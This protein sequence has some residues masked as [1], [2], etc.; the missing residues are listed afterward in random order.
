MI[1]ANEEIANKSNK[2]PALQMIIDELDESYNYGFDSI[3]TQKT[4][5][6]FQV[7]FSEYSSFYWGCVK[8]VYYL[9]TSK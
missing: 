6:D 5:S 3:N 4:L 8:E 1:I 9:S 7:G 2:I